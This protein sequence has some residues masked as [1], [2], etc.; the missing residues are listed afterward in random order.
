MLLQKR[1]QEAKQRKLE[2]NKEESKPPV[3]EKKKE[4][5]VRLV[6]DRITEPKNL[7]F[8]FLT[9]VMFFLNY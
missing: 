7:N 1:V 6:K 2:G 9:I 4:K 8:S 5:K 3:K